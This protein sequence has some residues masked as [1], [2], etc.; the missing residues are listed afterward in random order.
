M[1]TDDQLALR[2]T[3]ITGTDLPVLLGL[4]PWRTPLDVWLEKQGKGAPVDVSEDMERGIFFEPGARQWYAH[5]TKAVRV[6]EPGTVVSAHNPLV[7]ATPDGVPVFSDGE[8]RCLEIKMPSPNAQREWGEPG[9]DAVPEY[10]LVQ[11]LWELA[12]TD[13]QRVDFFAVLDGKP[14]IFPVQRDTEL[15]G[16]LIQRAEKW[17]RDY[18][19]AG[20]PPPVTERDSESVGRL[21]RRH[22][23]EDYLRFD[24][25]P[26]EAQVVVEEFARAWHE[27]KQAGEK[28]AL[29]E[30]RVKM[31][32][33]G[34]PGVDGLPEETNLKRIDWRAEKS[35]RLQWSKALT[36]IQQ[37]HPDVAEIL[38]RYMGEPNRPLTPRA[39]K[40]STK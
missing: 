6:E 23:R 14:C 13:L 21:Y 27:E 8:R 18:V 38:S 11:G 22:T 25:L 10:Y 3:G 34:A 35:G 19:V 32:L 1:L 36:E 28:L 39:R 24:A 2:R 20:K 5:R 37:R 15:E 40:E 16:L 26:V 12:A 30:A 31:A 9:T 4:S 7:I 17:W 33:A 29:Y